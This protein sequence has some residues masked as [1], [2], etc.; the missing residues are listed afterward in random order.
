[1]HEHEHVPFV[2]VPF[3]YGLNTWPFKTKTTG[4]KQRH[5]AD[6][7]FMWTPLLIST[8]VMFQDQNRETINLKSCIMT[9]SVR[10]PCF[11]TQHQSARPRPIFGLSPRSCPKT[12][13][14]RPHH[15]LTHPVHSMMS[16]DRRV[17]LHW[18]D[19]FPGAQPC[20]N[21]V[22]SIKW[23]TYQLVNFAVR[24]CTSV[25]SLILAQLATEPQSQ[26]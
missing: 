14:L 15:C 7:T 10:I 16:S 12:G 9:T 6:L 23:R 5:L 17:C 13:G 21:S 4:S 22:H 18:H 3:V 8:V 24:S 11:T 25:L 26:L 2:Y 20:N 1:M 19:L